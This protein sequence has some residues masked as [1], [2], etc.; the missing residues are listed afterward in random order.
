MIKREDALTNSADLDDDEKGPAIYGMLKTSGKK[1]TKDDAYIR[2]LLN[3][4]YLIDIG[5]KGSDNSTGLGFLT[6]LN[7]DEFDKVWKNN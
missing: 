7:K 2:K 1:P 4:K 5:L 6:Y 3:K